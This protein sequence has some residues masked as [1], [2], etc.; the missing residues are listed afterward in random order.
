MPIVNTIRHTDKLAFY[1]KKS[2]ITQN[3]HEDNTMTFRWKKMDYIS[4]I[5]E[6]FA[7]WKKKSTLSTSQKQ[8]IDK[9]QRIFV[10]RDIAQGEENA[11]T[12]EDATIFE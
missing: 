10:L 5:D 12:Q 9:H 6:L 7:Q 3:L 8:E 4:K 11:L 2:T 1:H